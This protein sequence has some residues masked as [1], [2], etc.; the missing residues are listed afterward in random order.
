[1]IEHIWTV[2]CS[3]SVVDRET[4]NLSLFNIVEQLNILARPQPE[5]M[6]QLS[7]D[8]VTLWVRADDTT[9]ARGHSRLTLLSPT[10]EELGQGE[11]EIDLSKHERLR[12]RR[13]FPLGLDLK[14]S[15]RYHFRVEL[16]LED[17][18]TWQTVAI[19]PLKVVVEIPADKS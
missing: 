1:M 16:Q 11:G 7:L 8:I 9:P 2:V 6:P 10:G 14:I 3:M 12:M 13:R 19:I 15:G 18:E 4:N 5:M 17:E